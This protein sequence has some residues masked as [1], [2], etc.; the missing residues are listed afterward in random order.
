MRNVL[1]LVLAGGNVSGFGVL[2]RNR[3]KAALG[4]G[5]HYRVCDFALSNL[6]NSSIQEVGLLIQYLPGSLMGHVGSGRWWDLEGGERIFK[7]MPPFMGFGETNWFKGTADSIY[8]NL[9]FIEGSNADHVLILSCEHVYSMNFGPLVASHIERQAAASLV[10]KRLEP[11]RCSKRFGYPTLDE[12]SGRILEMT[13][14]PDQPPGNT[15]FTGIMLFRRD[16]LVQR[17]IENARN[18]KTNNLTVDIVCPL[19]KEESCYAFEHKGYWEYLEHLGSYYDVHMAMARGESPVRP[20]EWDVHTNL[21]Y[22][23]LGSLPPAKFGPK[24]EIADSLVSPGA[25]IHGKVL[26]SVISPGVVVEEG[27]II[28]DSIIMHHCLVGEKASL[29]RVVSDKDVVFGPGCVIGDG[30]EAAPGINPELPPDH[31]Q[32]IV[33]GKGCR[34]AAGLR[35]APACQLYPGTDTEALQIHEVAA[36]SNLCDDPARWP[37]TDLGF[38]TRR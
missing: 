30:S 22:R 23:A 4:F 27:A 5:G 10:V 38:S 9:D 26:R 21:N 36:G 13:E 18:P 15:A 6:S 2:T 35:V 24:A 20:G 3:A 17:L 14:K 16:I 25:E 31:R 8:R 7:L 28:E 1:A 19:V 29:R 33:I 32:L 11:H 37:A 34:M 12:S